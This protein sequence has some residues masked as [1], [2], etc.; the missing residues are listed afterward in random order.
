MKKISFLLAA[1][2]CSISMSVAQVTVIA[3]LSHDGKLSHYTG[4]DALKAAY[5]AAVDGDIITL[6]PGTFNST[7][8]FSKGITVR[9]AGIDADIETYIQGDVYFYSK[10]STLV[11]TIEGIK[12]SDKVK[13]GNDASGEGQGKMKFVKNYFNT[14]VRFTKA[15]TYSSV[16]GPE[17]Y[18]YDDVINNFLYFDESTYPCAV[19]SNCFVTVPYSNL[20]T[21]TT[22][23]FVNCIINY[24]LGS[25][26]RYYDIRSSNYLTYLN[27]IFYW[28]CDIGDNYRLPSTA[29]ALSCLSNVWNPNKWNGEMGFIFLFADLPS[30]SS[31][32]N[33]T[34]TDTDLSKLFKTYRGGQWTKGETFELTDSI[35][36][37]YL[38]TDG[39]QVGMQ[40]G[41]YPYTSVVSYPV[42]TTFNAAS[43]TTKEGIL[44]VE[45]IV[46]ENK[47]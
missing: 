13:V 36:A 23:T 21:T 39:T 16:S 10:D 46:D 41:A 19:F 33:S 47:K 3:T 44:K 31:I 30:G 5:N 4:R 12:F 9:G 42:I 37:L 24:V 34:N 25:T 32:N 17:C 28:R 8:D 22:T 6:S 18:F 20:K 11:T 7:G 40:G 14:E 26:Y 45:A 27:C 35:A 29:S 2:I 15:G 1:L 38:G 43:A